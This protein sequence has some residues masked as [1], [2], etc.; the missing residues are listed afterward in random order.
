MNLKASPGIV[1]GTVSSSP[2]KSYTH[3]AFFLGLL[4]E[5][6]TTVRDALM[7]EDPRATI[8]AVR[9]LGATVDETTITSDG[10]V[11]TPE[12]VIDCLNSGTTMR[13]LA[14]IASLAPGASVLTG[15]ASLRKRPMKPLLDAL[16]SLGVQAES[17]RGNGLA[18]VIVR[19]PLSG[20]KTRIAGDISSQFVSALVLAGAR[21]RDGIE[22]SIDGELKSRPYVD[23]TIEMMSDFGGRVEETRD[24]FA[25]AGGQRLVGRE[26]RVPGDF[27]TAAF[28]LSAG[29]LAGKVTVDNLPSRSAQGD[30]A[31][32]EMLE[33]F[34]ARVTRGER[35]V[36][37]ETAPLRGAEFDLKDTPDLFPVLCAVAAHA[38]GTTIL[39]GARHLRFKESDRIHLM[40]TNLQRLGVDCEEREDG[41][42]IRGGVV[43]A[44][45]GLVTEGDHRILMALSVCALRAQ[46]PLTMDES[47]AHKVSYPSFVEDF[48][49]LGQPLEVVS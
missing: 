24:G 46:G 48:Q 6:K 15:D 36:T 43:R 35:S 41:A 25:V 2:S 8:D 40:V 30:K 34:G 47:D 29:A 17:T 12:D 13:L 28:P 4:S 21:S 16:Q 1:K 26:Y 3:R 19:G 18:P 33:R 27:S 23:I 45:S 38:K 11:H 14:A 9:A 31:I 20:G 39:S 32:I 7:S 49:R 37:V 5:G 10:R 44:G 22:I 42:I